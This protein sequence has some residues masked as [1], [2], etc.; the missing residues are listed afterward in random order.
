MF[1]KL[2]FLIPFLIFA[3][4]CNAQK[5]RTALD[6][7]NFISRQQ[8]LIV[9]SSWRYT[10]AIAHSKDDRTIDKKRTILIRSIDRAIMKITK[11]QGFEGETEYKE[12]VLRNLEINKSLLLEDY[13]E[14]IDMQAVAEQSYDAM[15]AY[16]LAQELAD[17]KMAEAQKEYEENFY[18]Y[19]KKHDITVFEG[20]S[21]LG[22]KMEISNKVFDYHN[23]LYLIFF[24]VHF[25]ESNLL[26]AIKEKDISAIRQNINALKVAVQEGLK[27]VDSVPLYKKDDRIVKAVKEVFQI[28]LNEADNTIPQILDYLVLQEDFEKI[29]AAIEKTPE[30]DRTNEQIDNYNNKVDVLNEKSELINKLIDKLFKERNKKLE[31]L[32][33]ANAKFLDKHVPKYTI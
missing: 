30:T 31:R 15:E 29:Q 27:D 8:V 19:A 18:A 7:M 10:Q 5:F 33:R 23:D 16:I 1:K 21:E 20:Q 13:A 26:D 14:I 24:K 2:L 28:H 25:N 22:K 4:E 9:K 17:Q 6:Y 3:S 12:K 11:A 32:D